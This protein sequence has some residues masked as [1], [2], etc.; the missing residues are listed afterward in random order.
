MKSRVFVF[1]ML[2][3]FCGQLLAQKPEF[4]IKPVLHSVSYSGVWRGHT[5]LTLDQF[6]VKAKSLGF[7]RVMLV[8]KRPHLAPGDYDAAARKRLRERIKELG[9]EV[10]SLA[11]YTDYTA[12]IDKPGIPHAEIQAAYIGEVA[13][14][15]QDL[16]VNMVRVFTGYERPSIP[17][18][19]QWAAVVNGLK[20]SAREAAK[21]GVTLAVQNHHDLALHHESMLWLLKEVNEPNVKAGFDAWSPA[22]EGMSGTE[23][24]DAVHKMAPY[25]VHTIVADYKKLPRFRYDPTLVNY[26]KQ[27][28]DL[29]RAV[30]M[31]E[32]F[33][34]YRAFFN[35]L[36]DIG[37][38]GYVAYELCEVLE[39][40]GSEENLDRTAKK[41]LEY[42]NNFNRGAATSTSRGR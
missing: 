7:T 20:L 25:L 19:Q 28:T 11:G 35:A 41:F 14:L 33:I 39:G 32:G 16:G 2:L 13:R 8:A 10:T 24:A 26:V 3:V 5:L 18:D 40:G 23:M 34:D 12:G 42:V 15:A 6:L 22:L 36:R 29:V 21:Y 38:Q 1:V 27:E 30:P 4:Q 17:Y 31:G 9:L 37:Y